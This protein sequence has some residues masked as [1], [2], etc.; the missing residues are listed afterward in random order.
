M[1]GQTLNNRYTINKRL[2]KGAMGTVYRAVDSQTGQDVAVK[3]IAREL[4]IDPDMLELANFRSSI[5]DAL[6]GKKIG[7]VAVSMAMSRL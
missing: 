7:W 5:W 6:S 3:L 2:G 4:A 1:I